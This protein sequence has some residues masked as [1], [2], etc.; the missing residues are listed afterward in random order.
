MSIRARRIL[1]A[2]SCA[3]GLAAGAATAAEREQGAHVHGMGHLDVAVEGGTVDLRLELPGA[4]IV[5]FEH[6]AASA[7]D[8]AAVAN[9]VAVL[10]A[11]AALF[12]FPAAAQCRLEMAEVESALVDDGHGEP[13][14]GE[15]KAELKEA[16]HAEFHVHYRFR[17]GRPASL[18]HVDVKIFEKFPRARELAAQTITGRGQ[19]AR[20]LTPA[21]ARLTF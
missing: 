2:W 7:E 8:K 6:A 10:K 13:K 21:S 15:T 3:A 9:A 11:G 16:A 19:S 14:H 20:Q 12:A 1:L 18:S 5:G 4:D 17:C